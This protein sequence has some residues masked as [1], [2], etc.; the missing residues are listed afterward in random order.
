MINAGAEK[1]IECG[2]KIALASMIGKII[3]DN[4]KC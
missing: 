1:F 2:N 4:D 3:E